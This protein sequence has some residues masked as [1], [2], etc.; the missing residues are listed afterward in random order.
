[1]SFDKGAKVSTLTVSRVLNDANVVKSSTRARVMKTI[2]ELKS[3]FLRHLQDRG[4]RYARLR[5]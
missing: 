2:A 5:P 1:M 3:I 4:S